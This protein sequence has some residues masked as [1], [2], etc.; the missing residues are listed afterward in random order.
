MSSSP[1]GTAS[2]TI[3]STDTPALATAMTSTPTNNN[4]TSITVGNTF[5]LPAVHS[6]ALTPI[7]QDLDDVFES[8]A[9]T[10]IGTNCPHPCLGVNNPWEHP[11]SNRRITNDTSHP[12]CRPTRLSDYDSDSD[13]DSDSGLLDDQLLR[14][15]RLCRL[16]HPPLQRPDIAFP[17]PLPLSDPSSSG[18]QIRLSDCIAQEFYE[19]WWCNQRNAER[20][21]DA[22][23]G[24][25]FERLGIACTAHASTS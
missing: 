24:R 20:T 7:H 8:N 18:E 12:F 22:V 10:E 19:A 23:W 3:P 11:S 2:A 14:K 25:L 9:S 13:S 6:H 5:P 21:D 4:S 15:D 1:K 16:R 17:P